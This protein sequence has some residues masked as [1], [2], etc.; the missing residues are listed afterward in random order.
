MSGHLIH[1]ESLFALFATSE[2]I[3][4]TSRVGMSE[5]IGQSSMPS[6]FIFASN[7]LLHDQRVHELIGM[8]VFWS[9]S[10]TTVWT[11]GGQFECRLNT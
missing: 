5:S 10:L 8:K 2:L 1:F 3:G 6:T 4:R 11:S 7:L 9:H